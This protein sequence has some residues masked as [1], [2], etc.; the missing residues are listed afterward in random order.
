MNAKMPELQRAF[1]R[2][3]FTEVKTVLASGNVVFNT[4]LRSESEIQRKAESAMASHLGR[5]FATIVRSVE[6]LQRMLERDPYAAFGL[7]AQAKRVVTFLRAPRK[8]TLALPIERD[9]ARILTASGGEVFTAYTPSP[10]GPVF[11]TL[12]AKTLGSEVTTRTWETITKC[13]K[14]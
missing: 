8:E 9:G 14:A 7:P 6:S 2:A 1:A 12:I 5:S 10:R 4:R 13:V 11:M 3:G